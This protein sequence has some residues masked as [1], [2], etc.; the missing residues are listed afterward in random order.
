LYNIGDYVVQ[1]RNNIISIS[2][3][4]WVVPV[5]AQYTESLPWNPESAFIPYAYV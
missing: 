4:D 2:I 5:S 3:R 1:M